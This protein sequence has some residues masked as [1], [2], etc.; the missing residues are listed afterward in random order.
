MKIAGLFG[1][2]IA[3]LLTIAV[4]T[5][6]G[7]VHPPIIGTQKGFRGVSMLELS[8]PA[9]VA[10]LK[11]ANALPDLI[12]MP[13][14]DD[15][16]KATKVYKN[17][18]VLTDLTA[19]QL[20][21]L[22]AAITEWVSPKQGCNYCHTDDLADDSLYTKKVSRR[23]IEMTRHVNTEWKSH[24]A[25]TGVVCWTCHRG[26][27]VPKEAWRTNAGF[28]QAGG[29][30][31]NNWGMGHPNSVNG[32]TSMSQD[33]FTPLFD[34]AGVVR[35]QSGKA[36]PVSGTFGAPLYS[37]YQ[38]YSLMIAISNAMGVNCT[39]CHNTRE[40]GVWQES[41]P[42]RLT[43]WHGINLVRDLNTA[44]LDPLKPLLPPARLGASGD[45]PRVNCATCHQGAN[46]PLLGVSL[47]KGFPELGGTP[48]Q[49]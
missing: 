4:L 15:G 28:P 44:Y 43:A 36:L 10:Q 40:F 9:A 17:V 23:M 7:W 24:V 26:E 19:V 1:V 48:A 35:I 29:A 5:T 13:A 34:K 37:T 49:K 39:F 31:T 20:N 38:T 12:E 47:A 14:A 2:V 18:Q 8:T 42:Q 25:T 30:T 46:K 6:A 16:P 32:S 3:V 11:R 33:P 21:T 27:P 22:M 45:V 41:T